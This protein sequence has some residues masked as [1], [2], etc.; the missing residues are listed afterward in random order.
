MGPLP[1]TLTAS[2]FITV[3]RAVAAALFTLGHAG[4]VDDA[5]A[6][7]GG[8]SE[9]TTAENILTALAGAAA[10]QHAECTQRNQRHDETG[11]AAKSRQQ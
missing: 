3:P 10:D 1:F 9:C 2:P 8:G 5:S 11:D 6:S 4:C 7:G